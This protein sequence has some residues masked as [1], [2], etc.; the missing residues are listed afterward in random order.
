MHIET[1]NA[2][3]PGVVTAGASYTASILALLLVLIGTVAVTHLLENL[4]NRRKT[5]E[6]DGDV[7]EWAVGGSANGHETVED[8]LEVAFAGTSG[9]AQRAQAAGEVS[10]PGAALPAPG[11]Q[12]SRGHSR[13]REERISGRS[14]APRCFF[15]RSRSAATARPPPMLGAIVVGLVLV[16]YQRVLLAWQTMLG[17]ILL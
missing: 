2:P 12:I 6:D 17:L 14:S 3:S 11:G 7:D 15:S 10:S 16:S 13:S 8:D 4:R 9:S 1:I 5:S